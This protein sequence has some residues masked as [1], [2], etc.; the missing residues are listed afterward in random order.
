MAQ[1]ALA[2]DQKTL[3]SGAIG[4]VIA[5]DTEVENVI[6]AVIHLESMIGQSWSFTQGGEALVGVEPDGV[7]RRTGKTF[8]NRTLLI[9][10]DELFQEPKY[11]FSE[12]GEFLAV[13]SNE[14]SMML[15]NLENGQSYQRKVGLGRVRVVLVQNDGTVVLMVPHQGFNELYSLETHDLIRSKVLKKTILRDGMQ[16]FASESQDG[17]LFV[18]TNGSSDLG[19]L[20]LNREKGEEYSKLITDLYVWTRACFSPDGTLLAMR[21]HAQRIQGAVHIYDTATLNEKT[22]F[23]S[24]VPTSSWSLLAFSAD[25]RRFV[26][27]GDDRGIQLWDV[28]TGQ[29]VIS[30]EVD[31]TGKS[32]AAF[33]PDGEWL[34][35]STSNGLHLWRAATKEEIEEARTLAI[36]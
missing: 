31:L 20:V 8:E 29:P 2:P 14:G 6:P 26:A 1:L 4:A 7:V 36:K 32:Y 30:L 18:Q 28:E 19:A 10:K 33:S 12:N 35:C 13:G 9:G 22:V 15:F 5:W 17:K 3:I 23:A 11:N 27:G 34:G 24:L 16:A 25:S 21:S